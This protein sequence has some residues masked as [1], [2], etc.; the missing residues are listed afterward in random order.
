MN[1]TDSPSGHRLDSFRSRIVEKIEARR[2]KALMRGRDDGFPDDEDAMR[3]FLSFFPAPLRIYIAMSFW[4]L[5]A[6]PMA[7]A[8]IYA[9]LGWSPNLGNFMG[10][11]VGGFIE[12]T[13]L[14]SS[15]DK[16]DMWR[17]ERQYRDLCLYVFWVNV[18]VVFFRAILQHWH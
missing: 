9:N 11:T 18:G 2:A 5:I 13:L 16:K 8:H 1:K 4:T 10:L 12:G 14:L 6:W 3:G 17:S 15:V 7:F